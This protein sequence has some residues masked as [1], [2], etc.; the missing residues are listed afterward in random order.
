[1]MKQIVGGG[2][3]GGCGGGCLQ[4]WP[5]EM[6]SPAP[7]GGGEDEGD[8]EEDAVVMRWCASTDQKHNRPLNLRIYTYIYNSCLLRNKSP[9]L[10][11]CKIGPPVFCKS[12]SNSLDNRQIR[13]LFNLCIATIGPTPWTLA[14]VSPYMHKLW[15]L[16]QISYACDPLGSISRR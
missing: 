5:P 12:R 8:D 7:R 11:F 10:P 16:D 14:G 15:F 2:V 4:R 3:G 9:H 13:P 1:M 6:N